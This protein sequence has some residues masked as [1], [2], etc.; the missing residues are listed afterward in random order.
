MS[1]GMV[2]FS[3]SLT[4][5]K[6]DDGGRSTPIQSGFRTDM[7]FSDNEYR[8][9]V[10]EFVE[11]LLFPGQS[12]DAVCTVLLHGEREIDKLILMK[13]TIIAD[14]PHDIGFI[15]INDVCWE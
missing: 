14:G 6:E 11:D 4:L 10:I 8:M 2:S 3:I 13:S 1:D 9:V 12:C 5:S 15:K 7:K